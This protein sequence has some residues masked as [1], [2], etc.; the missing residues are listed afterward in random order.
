MSFL[1]EPIV[2][3]VIGFLVFVL[4]MSFLYKGWLG[5]V[6]GR[7]TYWAGFL[8]FTMISPWCTHL[9]PGKRSLVKTKEGMLAHIFFGPSFFLC[10]I[11][12]LCAGADLMHLPGTKTLNLVLNGGDTT[13]TEAVS[14]DDVTGRYRFPLLD[15]SWKKMY[16]QLFETKI[17]SDRTPWGTKIEKMIPDQERNIDGAMVKNSKGN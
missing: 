12:C 17:D 2:K 15:R 5:C 14:F 9:P 11:L 7:F 6:L 1:S 16:R 3:I 10:G 4:G 13:K 8:P